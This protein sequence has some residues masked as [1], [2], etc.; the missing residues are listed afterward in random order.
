MVFDS[1]YFPFDFILF[2]SI[3]CLVIFVGGENWTRYFLSTA[4]RIEAINSSRYVDFLLGLMRKFPSLIEV[5]EGLGQ[6]FT[7]AMCCH[8]AFVC[9]NCW[10]ALKEKGFH[11]LQRVYSSSKLQVFSMGF[12]QDYDCS[13]LESETLAT[14]DACISRYP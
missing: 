2:G 10:I 14:S 12:N 9:P 3:L 4:E 8:P 11:H 7:A 6:T 1:I 13:Y 5:V